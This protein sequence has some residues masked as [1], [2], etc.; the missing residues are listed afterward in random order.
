MDGLNDWEVV[1]YLTA[2]PYPYSEDDAV[3]WVETRPKPTP[4]YATFAI[5]LAG[6]G[7][8]GSVAIDSE[9]G[10]WLARTHHGKGL[11]TEACAVLLDWHFEAMPDHAVPSGAHLGNAA[12]LN[13]QRKLGFVE[14][15]RSLRFARPHG[16]DVEHVETLLTRDAYERARPN[17]GRPRWM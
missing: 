9:L 4:E 3:A 16:R 17:L 7:M 6:H 10:Y 15:S 12:S 13:V 11:M 5:E 2:V 14:V 8:V 1:R